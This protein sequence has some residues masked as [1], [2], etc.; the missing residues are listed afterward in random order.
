MNIWE[1]IVED[2]DSLEYYKLLNKTEYLKNIIDIEIEFEKN[3]DTV[4]KT[5]QFSNL[6]RGIDVERVITL[7]TVMDHVKE[8]RN[9]L[10]IDQDFISFLRSSIYIY[11]F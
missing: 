5:V 2:E 4:F 1:I 6:F 7:K 11:L 3:S 10:K 8:F 9:S